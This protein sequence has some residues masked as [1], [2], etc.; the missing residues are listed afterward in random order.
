MFRE[1]G[2]VT[3][4]GND[5]GPCSGFVDGPVGVEYHTEVGTV[6]D[7]SLASWPRESVCDTRAA[8]VGHPLLQLVGRFSS[9]ENTLGRDFSKCR[10]LLVSQVS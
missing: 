2:Y 8:P 9:W 7:P 5:Q 10:G 1:F 6:E 4:D 3:F